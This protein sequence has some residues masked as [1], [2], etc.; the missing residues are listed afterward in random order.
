MDT[1]RQIFET[2]LNGIKS[3]ESPEEREMRRPDMGR[4]QDPLRADIQHDLQEIPAVQSQDRPPVGMDVPD[5]L[6]FL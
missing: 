5:G 6:Q 2:F 3:G 4:Y 1:G